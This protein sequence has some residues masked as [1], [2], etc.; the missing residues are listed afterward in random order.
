ML[1]ST[2]R[3]S[4]A[5]ISRRCSP[6]V[7]I[8]RMTSP[9]T[10][11]NCID[12]ISTTRYYS[13]GNGKLQL[14]NRH[15]RV[16]RGGNKLRYF[17]AE[18]ASAKKKSKTP[19]DI[20]LDNLGSLFLSAIALVLVTL[21]RSSQGTTN[22]N[23]LRTLI[24]N[25]AALDPFEVDDLRTAN[26]QFT[27]QIYRNV[28]QALKKKHGWQ[29]DQKI[30]YKLFVSAVIQEMKGIKGEAFTIQFGHLLDRVIVSVINKIGIEEVQYSQNEEE[31]EWLE[32][33]LLLVALSLAMNGSV[34]ERVEALYDILV[35]DEEIQ[36][37]NGIEV[38]EI[39]HLSRN[40]DDS[41]NGQIVEEKDIVKMVDYL[42]KTCQLVPDGQIIESDTKYPIQEYI[43]GSPAE[44][45][46]H[47]KTLKK[48]DLSE[49]A[50]EGGKKGWSCDDFHHLLKSKSIC[51]W[52]ECY[53][54]K[55]SLT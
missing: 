43:V 51:A 54:K 55:K 21:V 2:A 35:E 40:D 18:A 27:P 4:Q 32:V 36:D 45:M 41:M 49:D 15:S 46:T 17:T 10:R 11:L 20:F 48:D 1:R 44:L 38:A 31:K 13:H 9:S 30:D 8:T 16:L 39:D 25:T 52:G 6:P 37:Q 22:K 34:R 47:G 23:N 5:A 12:T 33:R 50:L 26:D 19:G 28:Y 29:L 42:Q 7:S 3:V 14:N 53:V 24:E